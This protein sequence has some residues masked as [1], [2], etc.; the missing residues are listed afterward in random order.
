M[1]SNDS[2]AGPSRPFDRL[3]LLDTPDARLR[4][5]AMTTMASTLAH[6][7]NQPL[8]AATNYIHASARRLR[9]QGEGHDEVLAMIEHAGRETVKAGE[10]IRRM[11]SFITTGKIAGRRESLAAMIDRA[12]S[13][14]VCPDGGEVELTVAIAPGADLVIAERI[15][16]EQVITNLL[17]NACEALDGR[18]HRRIAIAAARTGDEIVVRIEDNGPGLS[19]YALARLFEPLFTT[20]EDGIGLG[21]PICKTIVEA[22]GGR[23]WAETPA[24]GGACFCLSL[25][26]AESGKP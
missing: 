1:H 13:M 11:R 14:L 16:I 12:T 9:Q 22:H 3:C 23:L 15:Q 24:A 10:I 7:V 18:Q 25:P 19:D 4:L 2:A 20:K 8:A 17:G 6:E 5:A 21:M 26:A